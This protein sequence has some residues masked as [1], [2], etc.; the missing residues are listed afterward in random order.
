MLE[1][2]YPTM[3]ETL[4]TLEK[5][6]KVTLDQEKRAIHQSF[7]K[8]ITAAKEPFLSEILKTYQTNEPLE[9]KYTAS[10]ILNILEELQNKYQVEE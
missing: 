9:A 7:H 10:D 4:R 3:Y 1:Y 5:D 8:E 6:I 2:N